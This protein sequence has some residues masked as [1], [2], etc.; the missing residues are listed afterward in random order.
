MSSD[1]QAPHYKKWASS[2]S[3]ERGEKY[4]NLFCLGRR[5]G[6]AVQNETVLAFWLVQV[7][8]DHL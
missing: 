4:N 1:N 2:L 8:G 7:D 6:K 5:S 3:T